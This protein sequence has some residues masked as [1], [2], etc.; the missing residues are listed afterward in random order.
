M[1]IAVVLGM[2]MAVVVVIVV[3]VAVVLVVIRVRVRARARVIEIV[4][5]VAI[6]IIFLIELLRK[7]FIRTSHESVPLDKQTPTL[8][9]LVRHCFVD[10]QGARDGEALPRGSLPLFPGLLGSGNLVPLRPS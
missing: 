6:A 5:V 10:R 2:I 9:G 1:V 7:K 4:I 8:Q 3:V